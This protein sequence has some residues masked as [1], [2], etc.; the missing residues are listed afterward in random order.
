MVMDISDPLASPLCACFTFNLIK[1]KSLFKTKSNR[2][3]GEVPTRNSKRSK[4]FT[5]LYEPSAHVL[6]YRLALDT[7][8][9]AAPG[10]SRAVQ[11]GT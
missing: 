3:R 11:R 10:L 8:L 5:L 9:V 6:P 4:T 7:A 2:K 1:L